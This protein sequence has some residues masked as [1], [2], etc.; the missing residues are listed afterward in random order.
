VCS[1][2]SLLADD[3]SPAGTTLDPEK[4]AKLRARLDRLIVPAKAEPDDRDTVLIAANRVVS[5]SWRG[6]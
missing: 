6:R 2:V 5:T 1:R 3:A 4:L